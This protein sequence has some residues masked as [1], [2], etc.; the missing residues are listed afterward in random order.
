MEVCTISFHRLSSCLSTWRSP[1]GKSAHVLSRDFPSCDCHTWIC[2]C[3]PI[4]VMSEILDLGSNFIIVVVMENWAFTVSW[5][6]CLSS[7]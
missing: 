3:S 6:S 4:H 2:T 1:L 5:V 7:S